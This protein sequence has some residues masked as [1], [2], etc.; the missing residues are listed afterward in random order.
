MGKH[1]VTAVAAENKSK[2]QLGKNS[3]KDEFMLQP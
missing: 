3:C 1:H 2:K